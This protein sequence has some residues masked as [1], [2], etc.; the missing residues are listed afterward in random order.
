MEFE[1]PMIYFMKSRC[2]SL[3]PDGGA[4]DRGDEDSE[5]E[6]TWQVRFSVFYFI[7]FFLK[8]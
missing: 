8:M 6:R 7:F 1:D 5:K 4:Y 2:Y 3:H